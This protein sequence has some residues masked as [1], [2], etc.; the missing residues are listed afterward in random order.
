MTI[1]ADQG[2]AVFVGFVRRVIELNFDDRRTCV[3]GVC[4]SWDVDVIGRQ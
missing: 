2:L 3:V 1:E 4:V